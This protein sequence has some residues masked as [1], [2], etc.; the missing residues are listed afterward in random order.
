MWNVDFE[1]DIAV[2]NKYSNLDS[3][4]DRIIYY[5]LSE[6]NKTDEDKKI[7][8]NIWRILF[9]NDRKC[10]IDDSKHP[11]PTFK[12]IIN[13]VDNDDVSQ[14]DKR[15]FRSP[16]LEEAFTEQCSQIRIY[17]DSI[18][19][20]DHLLSQ[21]NIGIDILIHNKLSNVA[22]PLYDDN[23]VPINP[24]EEY[25]MIGTKNR[26]SILLR[27]VLALLN[28]A[29]IAGIGKLQFNKKVSSLA[30]S[31]MGSWNMRNFY[32]HKIIIPCQMS[33]VG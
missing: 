32:G 1:D 26:A 23:G 2:F 27:S 8:H 18:I 16:F 22:N 17:I 21:V 20:T 19:P 14:N 29:D 3:I 5:L 10:L 11:L 6:D 28:G 12:D 4:E 13:L 30:Q 25:P 24:T 31:R 33:G 9:Y 7:I 15:V